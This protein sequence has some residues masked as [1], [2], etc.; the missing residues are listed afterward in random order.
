M[1]VSPPKLWMLELEEIFNNYNNEP[2]PI[3]TTI[4]Y[5]NKPTSNYINHQLQQQTNIKNY[6]K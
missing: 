6:R 2:T 5:S 4:D 1:F 3:T